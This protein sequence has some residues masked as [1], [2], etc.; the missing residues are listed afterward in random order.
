MSRTVEGALKADA[1]IH[2]REKVLSW[3]VDGGRVVV[4]TDRGTYQSKKLVFTSGSW[5]SKPGPGFSRPIAGG[6]A[7]RWLVLSQETGLFDQKRLPV[8]ILEPT[9]N[10]RYPF[11][12]YGFPSHGLPGFKLG[13]MHHE[14]EIVESG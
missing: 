3:Q 12:A 6:E 14:R 13:V 2:A 9:K 11:N 5:M 7:G 10:A 1:Q 4:T 8:W